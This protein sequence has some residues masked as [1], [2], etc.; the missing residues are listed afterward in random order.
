MPI[1]FIKNFRVHDQQAFG[2]IAYEVME[3]A[4]QAHN[5]LGRFFDEDAYQHEVAH[6]LGSRAKIEVPILVKHADFSKTCFIDLLVDHGAIFELKTVGH[7][8]DEHR[9]QLISYLLLTG[10]RHGKLIN[11]RPERVEHEFVNTTLTHADRTSFQVDDSAWDNSVEQ[12]PEIRRRVEAFLRDWGTGLELQLY[13]EALTHFLGGEDQ[14]VREIEVVSEGRVISHQKVRCAGAEATFKI[15]ALT[16]RLESFES[17]A[18]K[19]LHHTHLKHM[20]WIN[21]NL[22]TVTL[23]T[24]TK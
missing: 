16:D 9:A 21:V 3:E 15:T 22:Q 13:V 1:E 18:M 8:T 20:L 6:A 7:L 5:K 2:E 10:G 19:F 24:L 23:K 12:A 14:V 17:N 11:F 4:F